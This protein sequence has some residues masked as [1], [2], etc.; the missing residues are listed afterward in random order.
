MRILSLL[1]ALMML[2]PLSPDA[3]ALGALAATA[4]CPTPVEFTTA[5]TP[6]ASLAAAVA[7]HQKLHILAV[8][9]ATMRPPGRAPAG[10]GF[11]RR[12]TDA[13]SAAWPGAEI[14]IEVEGRKGITAAEQLALIRS[15]LAQGGYQLVI[16]QTGTVDALRKTAPEQFAATLAEG[17]ALAASAGADLVLVDQQF[18]RMLEESA[19]LAPY[20]Q[21]LRATA[22][23]PGRLLFRRYDLMREWVNTGVI[24]LERAS[25]TT[26]LSLAES[27]HRCLGHALATLVINGVAR[28]S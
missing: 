10:T 5:S 28:A 26:R 6:L 2:L 16:W 18:S 17:A 7:V 1:A 20:Q 4:N 24:D 9:S 3:A 19:D 12:M 8:G 23:G 25:P 15:A 21:A 22:T 27:L 14:S 11:A 13:L